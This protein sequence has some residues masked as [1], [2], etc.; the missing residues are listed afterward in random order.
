MIMTANVSRYPTV[1]SCI[2][3]ASYITSDFSSVNLFFQD[4]SH[5]CARR[6]DPDRIINPRKLGLSTGNGNS[7]QGCAGPGRCWQDYKNPRILR[8]TGNGTTLQRAGP[9]AVEL[10]L[11]LSGECEA[12]NGKRET[13]VPAHGS[14]EF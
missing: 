4:S 14:R 1:Y 7:G 13:G 5:R 2:V 3:N 9:A 12:G 10:F 6:A 8:V 11:Y